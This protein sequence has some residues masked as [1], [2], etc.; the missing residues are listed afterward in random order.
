MQ[1]REVKVLM[2]MLVPG[3]VVQRIERLHDVNGIDVYFKRGVS[4][5]ELMV[6][7]FPDE[8]EACQ[9]YI[10]IENLRL[11]TL[12]NLMDGYST[13]WSHAP[14]NPDKESKLADPLLDE[15]I[16]FWERRFLEEGDLKDTHMKCGETWD[17]IVHY[18]MEADDGLK[19]DVSRLEE[20][21]SAFQRNCRKYFYAQGLT[22]AYRVLS[23]VGALKPE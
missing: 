21:D 11:Y 3:S 5:Q 12:Y 23:L 22:D 18:S 7:F 19:E 9:F 16:A 15:V 8:V 2:S 17:R 20:L 13:F 10:P 4:D 1:D 14:V 6:S